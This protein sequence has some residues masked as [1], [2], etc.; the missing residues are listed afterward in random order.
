MKITHRE[1]TDGIPQW[2]EEAFQFSWVKKHLHHTVFLKSAEQVRFK[3]GEEERRGRGR[4][5]GRE[6]KRGLKPDESLEANVSSPGNQSH[7]RKVM[8]GG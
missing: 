4:R 6:R 8:R 3:G 2:D 7:R 5:R 1:L